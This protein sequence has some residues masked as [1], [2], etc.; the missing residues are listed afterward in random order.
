MAIGFFVESRIAEN[1][2]F[3]PEIQFSA[4]GAKEEFLRIDYIQ[5]PLLLKYEFA[6][7]LVIG[8]G[9]QLSVK[10]HDYEDEKKNLAFSGIGALEYYLSDHLFIDFR[11]T[12]GV[13]N[14]YDDKTNLDAKNTNIQIGFGVKF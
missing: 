4:E 3:A 12:Y 7:F 10:G 2:S 14:I 13:T 1:L 9:P 8:V 11:Y 6:K 5:L